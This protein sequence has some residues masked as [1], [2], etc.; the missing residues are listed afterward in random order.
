[1]RASARTDEAHGPTF[2]SFE[3]SP[4]CG[5]A[6][7]DLDMKLQHTNMNSAAISRAQDHTGTWTVVGAG[8][9]MAI[10]AVLL[11]AATQAHAMERGVTDLGKPFVSG[12]VGA[13]EQNAL[14][15]EGQGY[16]LAILTAAKGTG[17]F[18]ADVRIHITDAQSHEVLDTLMDG[19]WLLVDLPAGRYEVEATRDHHAQKHTVSFL[20]RGHAE[21]IFYFD[22]HLENE[23]ILP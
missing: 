4:Y 2:A 20:A 6:N 17:N 16:G 13:A 19:P 5:D 9:T 18:L 15:A 23:A 3:H 22:N 21:T 8:F 10:S 7:G 12:G 1:M 14:R 11:C